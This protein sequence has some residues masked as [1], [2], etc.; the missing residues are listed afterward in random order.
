MAQ[1]G[2]EYIV[3]FKGGNFHVL[4]QNSKEWKL[5]FVWEDFLSWSAPWFHRDARGQFWLKTRTAKE[6]ECHKAWGKWLNTLIEANKIYLWEDSFSVKHDCSQMA[7]V[8]GEQC[9]SELLTL[10]AE[11]QHHI[12]MFVL[13]KHW[14]L[15][16]A[17]VVGKGKQDVSWGS[18]KMSHRFRS[19]ICSVCPLY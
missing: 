8:D 10:V 18:P 9:G 2:N 11:L 19:S 4:K 13:R 7:S 12:C 17:S 3:L 1:C 14:K 16:W 15:G 6:G 5:G